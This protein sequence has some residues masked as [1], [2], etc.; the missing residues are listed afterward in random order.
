MQIPYSTVYLGDAGTLGAFLHANTY[1][2]KSFGS[3]YF[4][5]SGVHGSSGST[6]VGVLNKV[7]VLLILHLLSN[8]PS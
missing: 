1:I 6:L 4:K 2:S 3:L 8:L 5:L 7:L